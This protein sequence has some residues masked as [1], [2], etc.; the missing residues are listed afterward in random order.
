MRPPD[1]LT[2]ARSLSIG[3]PSL[4]A[5]P[6]LCRAFCCCFP[7][8]ELTLPR[9]SWRRFAVLF[10]ALI[11][12]H[13]YTGTLGMEGA[14]ESMGTGEVDLNWAKQHHRLWLEEELGPGRTAAP[15]PRASAT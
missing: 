15:P 6:S 7:F 14:F 10:I 5:L 3:F 12:G 8:S 2:S 1:A 4:A 11:L 9:C 13:I